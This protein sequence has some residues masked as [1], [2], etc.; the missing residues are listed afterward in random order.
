M[1]VP[2]YCASESLASHSAMKPCCVLSLASVCTVTRS[3]EPRCSAWKAPAAATPSCLVIVSSWFLVSVP[4][5]P[6]PQSLM[7]YCA[8]MVCSS[9]VVLKLQQSPV[10]LELPEMIEVW[11]LVL[12]SL[13]IRSTK[14]SMCT[15]EAALSYHSPVATICPPALR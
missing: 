5:P 11:L 15:C 4:S 10:I 1:K 7:L 8:S 6:V 3:P 9:V 14:S 13:S 2:W 12:M